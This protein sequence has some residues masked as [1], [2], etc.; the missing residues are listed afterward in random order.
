MGLFGRK[1]SLTFGLPGTEGKEFTDLRIRF[2][3]E[4]RKSGDPNKAIIEVY[5]LSK[6]SSTLLQN[7][8][9]VVRLS[10]GYETPRQI[11]IGEPVKNGVTIR[12]ETVD[13]VTRI[14]ALD[15]GKAY[16]EARVDT[17]FATGTTL[18]EVLAV[19]S[20]SFGLP[21]GT[22]TIPENDV[23]YPDGLSLSGP[24][25]DIMDTL[26]ESV[27]ADW[28]INDG[29][30]N[31]VDKD[32]P[33]SLNG[34]LF[35]V[36]NGN[37]IGSPS[38]KEEGLIDIVSLLD[39]AIRPGTAFRVESEQFTGDYTARDVIFAGDSGWETPFYVNIVGERRST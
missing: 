9:V 38:P 30:I 34:P 37:L 22:T 29:V 32:Q 35:S 20:D 16:Q 11:F 2:R 13:R 24:S 39:P 15:S 14:E 19:V 6:E 18:E 1:V 27:G 7:P 23:N 17:T 8:D 33:A 31:F 3:V 10:A 12:R 21:F 25:R 4:H 36:S 26:A 5:N 28:F